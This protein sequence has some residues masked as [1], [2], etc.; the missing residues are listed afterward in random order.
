MEIH[1]FSLYILA[2]FCKGKSGG[3]SKF[4][5]SSEDISENVCQKQQ[6]LEDSESSRKSA[7]IEPRNIVVA[8][9]GLDQLI[10]WS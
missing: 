8:L 7:S 3:F 6:I 2:S 5:A 4:P 9:D 10:F 1:H